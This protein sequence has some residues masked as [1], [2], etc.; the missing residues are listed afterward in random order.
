MDQAEPA[1]S[2]ASQSINQSGFNPPTEVDWV[3]RI[4]IRFRQC[5]LRVDARKTGF[6]ADSIRIRGY[7]W[8]GLESEAKLSAHIQH[9]MVLTK[10]MQS[11]EYQTMQ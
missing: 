4:R 6:N 10:V 8:T 1:I 2:R 3:M 7:V 5:A 9:K 11:Y